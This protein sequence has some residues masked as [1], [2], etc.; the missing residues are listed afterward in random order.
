M[1]TCLSGRR[2]TGGRLIN[3]RSLAVLLSLLAL[4]GCGSTAEMKAV[5]ASK[6]VGQSL[7]SFVIAKGVPQVRQPMRDGRTVVEWTDNRGVG[8]GGA[9]ADVLIAS[10]G[11]AEIQGGS[12]QLTCKVRMVVSRAGIIEDFNI[13]ADTIGA[14]NLSR[15]AEALG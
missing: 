4:S 10:G 5:H 7:D 9:M 14:W 8:R 6:W 1:G 13:V 3:A 11:G 2:D 15:C 12:Y